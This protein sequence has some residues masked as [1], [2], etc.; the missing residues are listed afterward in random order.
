MVLSKE[1]TRTFHF[2]RPAEKPPAVL[3]AQKMMPKPVKP[4]NNKNV[5]EKK[6]FI[7]RL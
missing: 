4:Q 7:N 6:D 2:R 1:Q 5:R 3:P